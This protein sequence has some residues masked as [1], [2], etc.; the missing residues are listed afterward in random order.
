ME[1][2]PTPPPPCGL[3]DPGAVPLPYGMTAPAARTLLAALAPLA[4]DGHLV[5]TLAA[6]KPHRWVLA[7]DGRS[8]FA[9]DR[10]PGETG[11]IFDGATIALVPQ[12]QMVLDHEARATLEALRAVARA[13]ATLPQRGEEGG[14]SPEA[15][16]WHAVAACFG[17]LAEARTALV[18]IGMPKLD[19]AMLD[20]ARETLRLMLAKR[21][22]DAGGLA[23]A[24]Q[25]A[26]LGSYG[27]RGGKAPA[28]ANAAGAPDA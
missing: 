19:L 17:P 1:P 5:N 23:E 16:A 10:D 27:Y 3:A 6:M 28:A 21:W 15:K 7:P 2:L 9:S 18:A 20:E 22:V 8:L 11:I 13:L 14:E 12:R 25:A 4:G 24:G 26:L